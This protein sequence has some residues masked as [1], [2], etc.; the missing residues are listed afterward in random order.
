MSPI[1]RT[2]LALNL[3]LS[4][5]FLGFSAY[6]LQNAESYK[7]KLEGE[8][9]TW[10][11]ERTAKDNE[12]K[13][14][15]STKDQLDSDLSSSRSELANVSGDLDRS[16]DENKTLQ[17]R[18]DRVE[19]E[20]STATASL[21]GIRTTIEQ[22][23]DRIREATAQWLTAIQDKDKAVTERNDMQEELQT[24]KGQLA[25]LNDSHEALMAE[26]KMKAEKIAE[27]ETTLDVAVQKVPALKEI[28]VNAVPDIDGK[29]TAVNAQLNTVVLDVGSENAKVAKG[30]TFKVYNGGKYKGDVMITDVTAN[31][32]YARIVAP[33][34][35]VKIQAGDSATTRL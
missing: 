5:A 31:A 27:L 6:Y 14:L 26:T 9:T 4:G 33:A 35:D 17:G 22:Q 18:L 23:S 34:P 8:R 28:V 11:Q 20:L 2:F 12:I 7:S 3:V 19:G 21:T 25:R 24:V 29:I 1:G 15:R 30:Y 16:R 32:S 13:N 10:E